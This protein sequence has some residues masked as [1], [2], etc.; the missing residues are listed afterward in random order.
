MKLSSINL[1]YI[2]LYLRY[3]IISFPNF[4]IL[5]KEK[6]KKIKVIKNIKLNKSSYDDV[7]NCLLNLIDNQIKKS[8]KKKE[9]IILFLSSGVDSRLLYHI[10]YDLCKTNKYL[11]NFYSITGNIKDYKNRYSEYSI[12]KKNL[13]KKIHNHKVIDIDYKNFNYEILESCKINK[14]PINGLPIVTMKKLFYYCSKNFKKKVIITGIGDPIFFNADDKTIKNLKKSKSIQYSS[15]GTVYKYN[16]FLSKKYNSISEKIFKSL[17][18]KKIFRTKNIYHDFIMRQNFYLKGPKV[19]NEINNLS[20]YYKVKIFSPF[21]VVNLQRKILGLPIKLLFNGKPKSFI[22]E[23]LKKFE[24]LEP[25]Q[26]L[27]MN[28]P[29][30]E[31]IFEKY[32]Q[33]VIKIIK[34]S[35]LEKL[36]IIDIKKVFNLFFNHQKIFFKKKNKKSFK[37]FSSYEIWKFISTELFIRSL[38]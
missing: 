29:Q 26:G 17:Q 11:Y 3:G 12:L 20:K 1:K 27:K 36:K 6:K 25:A 30:R 33:D 7:F 24:G 22:N 5:K 38:K 19:R 14:K 13:K 23:M 15:D 21:C 16:N 35:K 2:S 4:N 8:K 37:N 9:K 18:F 34:N 28:S 32:E 10:I 31:F